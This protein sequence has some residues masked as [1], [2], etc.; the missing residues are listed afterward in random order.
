MEN[1]KQELLAQGSIV[2]LKGGYKKLMIV[3]RMQL[4][5]EEEKLWDY[6]GVLYPEGYLGN[7]YTF[8]FNNEDIDEV[9]FKGY[10][11]LEDEALK[12]AIRKYNKE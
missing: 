11:D 1:N 8:L 4:Q 9:I 12:L 3:G 10:S 7:D 6:L 5:G 2:V